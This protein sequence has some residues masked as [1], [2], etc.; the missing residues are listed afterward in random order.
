MFP[1]NMNVELD[2]AFD[3][4]LRPDEVILLNELLGQAEIAENLASWK[5]EWNDIIRG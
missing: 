1:A 3:Y 4:A 2:S 5:S